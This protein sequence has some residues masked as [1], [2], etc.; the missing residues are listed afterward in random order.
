MI[1]LVTGASSGI[2]AACAARL[3]KAGHTV[4]GASR[5]G[6]GGRVLDVRDPAAIDK[7]LADVE[8]EFGRIDAVVNSAGVAVGGPVEDTPLELV[9]A[10]FETNLMGAVYLF[11]AAA[12]Y[13]RR[14]A[15]SRM[16]HISSLAAHIALP[17]QAL[18]S[19]SHAGANA[20][21]QALRYEM[22][23]HGVRVI[24][25]EPGSFRTGLTTNRRS[26]ELSEPYAKAARTALDSN[27]RDELKGV[28]PEQLAELV[29]KLLTARNPPDRCSAGLWEERIG[30]AARRFLPERIF[31]RIIGSH[32]GV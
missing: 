16:I 1:V 20:F 31:R 29:E 3:E 14:S 6:K 13:L 15:P 2:G 11:R 4:V 23:P 5:S 27:D 32:Y 12:P 19:A 25:V 24:V 9:Q 18:Y 8:L 30:L 17:Y 7:L 28:D 26:P 10:Q 22:A 21:C